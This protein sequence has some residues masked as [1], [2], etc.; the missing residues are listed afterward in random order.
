MNDQLTELERAVYQEECE[1]RKVELILLDNDGFLKHPKR[2][3][4]TKRG[5]GRKR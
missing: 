3:K 5:G 1:R 2:S 4:R